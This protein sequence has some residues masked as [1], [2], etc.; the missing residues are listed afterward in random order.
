MAGSTCHCR[1]LAFTCHSLQP[2]AESPE[3]GTFC[4]GLDSHTIV[5]RVAKMTPTKFG[6]FISSQ[7]ILLEKGLGHLAPVPCSVQSTIVRFTSLTF[8]D[9]G[10]RR[11]IFTQYLETPPATPAHHL[12]TLRHQTPL[13]QTRPPVASKC[14]P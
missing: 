1:A 9:L 13:R 3:Y 11:R 4:F 5:F 8:F 2:E 6:Q 10:A 7:K 12:T 14:E